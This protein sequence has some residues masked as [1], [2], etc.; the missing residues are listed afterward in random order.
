[1]CILNSSLKLDLD[2]LNLMNKFLFLKL[3][4][5]LKILIMESNNIDEK[6]EP[7][8]ADEIDINK[9]TFLEPC[10]FPELVPCI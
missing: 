4:D 3:K 9:F 1:M 6:I 8:K 7:E 2:I 10:N 5:K